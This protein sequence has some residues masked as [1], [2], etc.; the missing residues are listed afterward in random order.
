MNVT[1]FSD[2]SQSIQNA[3]TTIVNSRAQDIMTQ[4]NP[5][6]VVAL[7]LYLTIYG[8]MILGGFVTAPFQDFIKKAFIAAIVGAFA[9]NYTYF[10][11]VSQTLTDLQTGMAAAVTGNSNANGF[12]MLDTTLNDGFTVIQKYIEMMKGLGW[13]DFG[14]YVEYLCCIFVTA[15]GLIVILIPGA[16]MIL[17]ATI[18]LQVMIALGPLFIAFLLWPATARFFEAWLSQVMTYIFKYAVVSL[19]LMIAVQIFDD[20]VK[21]VDPSSSDQSI[22]FPIIELLALAFGLAK[23]MLEVSNVSAQLAGG[24]S[25]SVLNATSI[26]NPVGNLVR[27]VS[28][29]GRGAAAGVQGAKKGVQWAASKI[30]PNKVWNPMFRQAQNPNS[31]N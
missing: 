20:H 13:H 7:A 4:I 9:L 19:I 8:Y 31:T 25:I 26:L 16:Y 17:I 23:V 11:Q 29:G 5:I 6:V 24:M 27:N 12:S 2:L 14:P 22:F 10:T 3:L 30:N 15:V 1:L 28:R 18:F 21:K